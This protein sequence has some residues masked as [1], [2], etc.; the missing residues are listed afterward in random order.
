[1]VRKEHVQ[2]CMLDLVF[3]VSVVEGKK[4]AQFC[5]CGIGHVRRGISVV[6]HDLVFMVDIISGKAGDLI[7]G[8]GQ[9]QVGVGGSS[10]SCYV[11]ISG[12]WMEGGS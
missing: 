6:N 8:L 9:G 1:M 5:V 3:R 10:Q 7:L 4:S 12:S 2:V 11:H